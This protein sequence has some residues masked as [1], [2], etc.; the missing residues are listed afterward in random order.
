MNILL[1]THIILWALTDD[2][3]LSIKA[4]KLIENEQNTLYVSLA[5]IWELQIKHSLHPLVI[6][7]PKT[8]LDS[9]KMAGY[10]IMQIASQ[11]IL[12][13]SS[14]SNASKV[15]HKDPFDRIL[16]STAKTYNLSFLTA[17]SSIWGYNE[18][19]IVKV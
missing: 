1:D 6:P 10:E 4:R 14:L 8:V 13:I 18:N 2:V 12:N 7:N 19:C 5:S 16:L 17:D 9:C 11:E 3:R 15:P